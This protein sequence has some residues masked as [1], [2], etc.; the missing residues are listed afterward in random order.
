MKKFSLFIFALAFLSIE[1]RAQQEAHYT[2]FMY[3]KLMLNPAYAGA[4]G[5]PFM[6]AVHRSQWLGWEG[7]PTSQLLSYNAPF[8]KDRVGVGATVSH[9]KRGHMRD[10]F[11]QLAYSYD[12]VAKDGFSLRAGLH[13]SLRSFSLN[14]GDPMALNLSSPTDE[15]IQQGNFQKIVGNVGA[16]VYGSYKDK[17]YG[18][19]S[20]PNIIAGGLNPG[21][22]Q[23]ASADSLALVSKH[24]Y[25]MGGLG[26]RLNDQI[27][28]L[29]QILVKYVPNAPIDADFNGTLEFDKK[30]GIG[31]TLR[32]GGDEIVE[33]AD[34]LVFFK[35]K[36][37]F[38]IGVSYDFTLSQ[39]KDYTAGSVEAM[40]SA[41]LKKSKN[42]MSNPRF[43][44]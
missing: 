19:L 37:Q 34:L 6:T 27:R 35:V 9:H 5:V 25:A 4:R 15:T 30:A 12:L 22:I 36:N 43:F 18:G 39:I 2:H 10:L 38:T 32:H 21:N 44:F 23:F 13:G 28:F 1:M 31:L 26:L 3:N 33:S 20:V 24:F 16:G 17:I 40:I 41:D 8:L 29:P 42:E 7:A 11:A 14:F